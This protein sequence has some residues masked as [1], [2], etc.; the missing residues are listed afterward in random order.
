MGKLFPLFSLQLIEY[1]VPI[2]YTVFEKGMYKITQHE[3]LIFCKTIQQ[4]FQ[5]LI[6][7]IFR[8]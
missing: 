3:W 1:R 5:N 8:L 2:L 4:I 7:D 6:D